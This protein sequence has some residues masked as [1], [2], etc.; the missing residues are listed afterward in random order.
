MLDINRIRND[1]DAVIAGLKIRNWKEED[2]MII[3]QL[4]EL[5]DKRKAVQAVS[6]NYLAERNALSKSIGDLFKQGK[7]AEAQALTQAYS[8]G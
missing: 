7:A 3:D 2:L 4:V 6:D 8:E 1:R 5:D